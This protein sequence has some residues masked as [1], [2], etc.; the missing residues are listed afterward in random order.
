MC[1]GAL[2]GDR[3]RYRNSSCMVVVVVFVHVDGALPSAA[4]DERS[5][6]RAHGISLARWFGDFCGTE[7]EPLLSDPLHG[8]VELSLSCHW[9]DVGTQIGG[10]DL[11]PSSRPRISKST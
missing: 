9:D 5:G 7:R 4:L 11:C 3:D 6:L 2:S 10:V 8:I 1:T